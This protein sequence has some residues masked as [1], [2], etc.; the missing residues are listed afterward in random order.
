ML[1]TEE[2]EGERTQHRNHR[3]KEEEQPLRG[4]IV[5]GSDF[6]GRVDDEPE[7]SSGGERP[8]QHAPA[9]MA[10][11]DAV[12]GYVVEGERE[13]GQQRRDDAVRIESKGGTVM[14]F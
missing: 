3:E 4:R 2:V 11:E 14:R 6:P 5:C 8:D 10:G 7:G 1:Q 9:V 13:R 12:P